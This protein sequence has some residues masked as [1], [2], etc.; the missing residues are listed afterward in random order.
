[1]AAGHAKRLLLISSWILA[2]KCVLEPNK[3]TSL[4]EKP[5]GWILIT[6]STQLRIF[7]SDWNR[8]C[9]PT[10]TQAGYAKSRILYYNN[11]SATFNYQHLRLSGDVSPNPGR[12]STRI[13]ADCGWVVAQNHRAT[14]RDDC[15]SWTHIKCGDVLPKE[16]RHMKSTG[17]FSRT[18]RPCLPL[19]Q[20]LSF[21]NSSLNS[22]S[23]SE[24]E[25]ITE[26]QNIT[27]VWTEFGNIA[28][29]YRSNF[30]DRAH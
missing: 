11:C 17:N 3:H 14:R 18:C 29:N 21:M 30:Q 28:Q 1:M 2:L 20:Q 22:S 27:S 7:G 8:K 6:R 23:N 26:E 9:F 24:P 5:S 12:K 10:T 13:C 19:L 16:Y 15:S 25:S 4:N